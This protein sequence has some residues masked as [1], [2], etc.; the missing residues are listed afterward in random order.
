MVSKIFNI[1]QNKKLM[2]PNIVFLDSATV[3]PGDLSWEDFHKIGIFTF[4][5]RTGP[6]EVIER[7]KNA[8]VLIV[9]KVKLNAT[10]FSQL[11]R[12]QLVCVAATGYDVIDIQAAK[13]YEST[14]MADEEK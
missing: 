8:D 14:E 10:H 4:Y 1:C 2:K 5:E 13:E 3:N 7:S 12:L 6:N 9:N 11:P